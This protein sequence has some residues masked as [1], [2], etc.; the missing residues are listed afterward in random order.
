LNPFKERDSDLADVVA[1]RELASAVL[2]ERHR[3][4]VSAEKIA[5]S[6]KSG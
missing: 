5:K 6:S 1:E 3:T 2:N 4:H